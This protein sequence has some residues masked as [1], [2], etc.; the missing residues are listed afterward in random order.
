MKKII[1]IIIFMLFTTGCYD[2]IELNDLSII[3]GIGI[4]KENNE[5][6][7]TYEILSEQ[8]SSQESQNALIVSGTGKTIAEAFNNA[9]KEVPKLT[10]YP[11]LKVVV[12]SEEFANEK[13]YDFIDYILRSPRI[14]NEFYM[15]I[16]KDCKA[17]DIFTKKGK[18]IKIVSTQ[19]ESMIKNNPRRANN[20][21]PYA[22]EEIAED[23]LDKKI[24]PVMSS[25][26]LKEQK[27]SIDGLAVFQDYKLKG[28]LS[29]DESYSYNILK[30]NAKDI[31]YNFSCGNDK[32]ITL[33]IYDAEPGIEIINDKVKIN[34]NVIAS[35]AEYNCDNSLKKPET[36]DYFNNKYN[37]E[38]NNHLKK[39]YQNILNKKTDV[40]GIS[41]TYYIKKRKNIDW[42]KLDYE[43]N[44]N[45]KI[46]N[47]GLIF[48]VK[49]W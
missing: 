41:N 25:I 32:N 33:T 9:T 38:I 44:T 48:E 42:T 22:F 29:S 21:A 14:R 8:K 10:F 19:I 49:K 45:L 46:N 2:Y 18:D 37:K 47:A 23:F 6:K 43:I 34:V 35:I 26:S 4:D 30:N 28:I 36:Y 20:A 3:S 15:V 24:D 16:A 5:Y 1:L 12:L 40:L 7:I 27:L 13:M 31:Q 11:H 39:F 17:N